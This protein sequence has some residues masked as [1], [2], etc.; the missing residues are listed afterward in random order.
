MISW[1]R[2]L[3][4]DRELRF[5]TTNIRSL[6]TKRLRIEGG[7]W[8]M[9]SANCVFGRPGEWLSIFLL[10]ETQ[11]AFNLRFLILRSSDHIE[12]SSTTTT[13][14]WLMLTTTRFRFAVKHENCR[15]IAKANGTF[16]AAHCD[17]PKKNSLNCLIWL[18]PGGVNKINLRSLFWIDRFSYA[19]ERELLRCSF[20]VPKNLIYSEISRLNLFNIAIPN[21]LL[22]LSFS[23][24]LARTIWFWFLF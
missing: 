17:C 12:I 2:S 10:P 14:C 24:F 20:E 3:F 18:R 5:Q 21:C 23:S 9:W 13:D 7:D 19:K 6:S 22:R 16:E 11:L 8:W 4:R 15:A 1:I